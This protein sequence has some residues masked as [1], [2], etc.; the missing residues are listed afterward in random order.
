[1][2]DTQ[3]P[4]AKGGSK[5]MWVILGCLGC[6]GISVVGVFALGGLG[7][8]GIMQMAEPQ[9]V[10]A[11]QFL[12]Q[13]AAGDIDGAYAHFSDELKLVRDKAAFKAEVEGNKELFDAKDSTFNFVKIENG[14]TQITGSITGK[15][16]KVYGARFRYIAQNGGLR[17]IKY[18]ISPTPIGEHD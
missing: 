10:D 18:Q 5:L 2:N 1:M 6:A 16:G 4:P 3:Q 12:A 17:M 14:V 8:Y 13:A 7:V 11:R 15:N 9:R